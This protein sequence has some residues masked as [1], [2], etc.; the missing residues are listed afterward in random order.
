MVFIEELSRGPP[1]VS[2][3]DDHDQRKHRYASKASD[4]S[5]CFLPE[6]HSSDGQHQ[7]YHHY[8]L[9]LLVVPLVT[10]FYMSATSNLKSPSDTL[11]FSL[12]VLSYVIGMDLTMSRTVSPVD[13][14]IE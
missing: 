10:L 11:V 3:G 7:L 13:L 2:R 12:G 9:L 6:E 5:S 4:C 14:F 8:P 1:H